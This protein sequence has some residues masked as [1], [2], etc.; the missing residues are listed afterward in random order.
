MAAVTGLH[1]DAFHIPVSLADRDRHGY[2]VGPR[3]PPQTLERLWTMLA[4][5]QDASRLAAGLSLSAPTIT[6]YIDLLT[7]LLLVRWLQ[8]LR[9]NTGKRLAAEIDLILELPAKNGTWAIEIKCS[10]AAQPARVV[11]LLSGR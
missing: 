6:N 7:D 5:N 3:I 8:L 10:L 4:H 9:A 1:K 11:R 2:S